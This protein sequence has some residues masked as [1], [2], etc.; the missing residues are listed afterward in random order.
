MNA[1]SQY[2]DILERFLDDVREA[3]KEVVS[4]VSAADDANLL[5]LRRA[6][7]RLTEKAER[8]I[9]LTKEP[10]LSTASRILSLEWDNHGLRKAIARLQ[11]E[12]ARL[13]TGMSGHYAKHDHHNLGLAQ[14]LRAT[15]EENFRLR[16]ELASKNAAIAKF[17]SSGRVFIAPAMPKQKGARRS[18]RRRIHK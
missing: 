6:Y 10:A 4:G 17:K 16:Q 8:L 7:D 1:V 13:K 5:W 18:P 9:A 12:L 11:K 14:E 3:T 2:E 15:V